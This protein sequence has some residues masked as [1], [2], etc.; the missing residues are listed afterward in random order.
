MD[1]IKRYAKKG[2]AGVQK[3]ATFAATLYLIWVNLTRIMTLTLPPKFSLTVSSTSFKNLFF[4]MAGIVM[5]HLEFKNTSLVGNQMRFLDTKRGKGLAYLVLAL[6]VGD[7]ILEYV[8][9]GLGCYS[10]LMELAK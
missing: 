3:Y 10:V 8:F 4:M 5:F 9:L 1:D 7:T 6:F 2:S